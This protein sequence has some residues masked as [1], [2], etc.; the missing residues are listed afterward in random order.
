MSG[1]GKDGR[2]GQ[3]G[4]GETLFVEK[5]NCFAEPRR[6]L[7][8]SLDR[9]GEGGVDAS[10]L[11]LIHVGVDDGDDVIGCGRGDD[12]LV[13]RKRGRGEIERAGDVG[14]EGDDDGDVSDVLGEE[15]ESERDG[16]ALCDSSGD[17][18][19]ARCGSCC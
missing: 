15:R 18:D 4:S 17:G 14:L 16:E 11:R 2:A 1:G 6:G 8:G 9:R 10:Y 19:E 3:L 7:L 5:R 12:E 13:E